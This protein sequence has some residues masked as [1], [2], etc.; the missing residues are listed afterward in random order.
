MV[1]SKLLSVSIPDDLSESTDALAAAQGRSR[2][3][4]VREALRNYIWRERWNEATRSARAS[5]ER[6]GVGPE[7][8]EDLVDELRQAS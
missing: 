3:E 2:S 6:M 7:D 8:V 4:V 5:A 1:M